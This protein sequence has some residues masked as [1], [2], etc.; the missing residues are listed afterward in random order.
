MQWTATVLNVETHTPHKK[1]K[2]RNNG[3]KIHPRY[4]VESMHK[5]EINCSLELNHSMKCLNQFTIQGQNQNATDM[6]MILHQSL[7]I[8]LTL[9]CVCQSVQSSNES[10]LIF[11]IEVATRTIKK[12]ST[13]RGHLWMASRH[14]DKFWPFIIS[15]R[16]FVLK[17]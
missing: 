7:L 6:K 16:I 13:Y 5:N 15:S 17:P 9:D 11:C 1:A 14:F 3:N 10:L 12:E 8:I 4:N 2:S